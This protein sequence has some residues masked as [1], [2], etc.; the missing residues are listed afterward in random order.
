MT[1]K[2]KSY[3]KYYT[4]LSMAFV[5]LLLTANILGPK[6]IKFGFATVPAGLIIFPLTY[7]IGGVLTEVYG[8]AASRKV[9]WAGLFSNLF[10]SIAC[11][12]AIAMPYDPVWDGQESYA[13]VLGVSSH[14]ML[15]SVFT[16][17]I[18]EF[19]NSYIVAKLKVKMS[20][21][22][23][24]L[25]SICG[26][27]IGEFVETSLFLPL[28]FY[29]L[30]SNVLLNMA[31]FYYVFKFIYCTLS[32]PL[33]NKFSNFLKREEDIDYYDYNTSFNPFLTLRGN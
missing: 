33:V 18:G 15:V 2:S 3:F 4:H 7:L 31:V 28:A 22:K 25:R 12:I 13:S 26:N 24:W 5:S 27:W 29:H 21:S 30:P 10:L 16:Y 6:P 20:G 14:L 19:V 1:N 8:F 17:F 32:A 11:K 9:I 23:F